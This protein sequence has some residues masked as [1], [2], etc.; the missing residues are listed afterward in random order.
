MVNRLVEKFSSWSMFSIEFLNLFRHVIIHQCQQNL[1][2]IIQF[3]LQFPHKILRTL[4]I[5]L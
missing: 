3:L 5:K 2:E 1:N 4:L